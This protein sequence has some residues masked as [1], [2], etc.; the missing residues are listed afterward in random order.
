MGVALAAASLVSACALNPS[1]D[2]NAFASRS[3]ANSFEV[4]K[5]KVEAPDTLVLPLVHDRQTRGPSC[6]AHALASIV[7]YW[8][9][10]AKQLGQPKITGEALFAAKP[11]LSPSGYSMAE[12]MTLARA[13]GLV[14]SAVRLDEAA[15]KR[16]LEAGRPVLV[17]VRLPSIYV[18]QRQLPG[19]DIPVVGWVRNGIIYRAGRVSEMTGM[20]VVDHYLVI[21]GYNEDQWIVL[22][23]VMGFRTM[24]KQKLTRYR[25]KFD[26]AALVFSA[27]AK[28][29]A[30]KPK[31]NDRVS[32]VE[33]A[34]AG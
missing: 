27:P 19:G 2:V 7:N 21:T 8:R 11:P 31:K 3:G 25:E 23:P 28:P 32:A 5:R 16:E 30:E 12:L 9:D 20:A 13:E 10:Q 17:P 18:Q 15:V 4:M 6:G 24:S 33:A 1:G 34:G 14:V 22:E 26:D 29:S